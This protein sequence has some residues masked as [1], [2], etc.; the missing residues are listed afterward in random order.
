[1]KDNLPSNIGRTGIG[2]PAQIREHCLRYEQAGIDQVI[3]VTQHGWT[4]HDHI[5]ES[6]ELFGRAVMPEFQQRE[7]AAEA[8]KQAELAPYL[9]AA[10]RR[11]N[12]LQP[13]KDEEIPRIRMAALKKQV[14]NEA[15][16][17]F[18]GDRAIPIPI[19]DP[20]APRS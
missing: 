9:E 13:M 14:V 18:F 10:M 11:K 15:K 19:N 17:A 20:L 7:A 6:L 16:T 3:F 2:T 4:R 12:G 5:C 1:M 8:R